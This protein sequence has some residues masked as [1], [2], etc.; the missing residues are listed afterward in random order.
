M[1]QIQ[2]SAKNLNL[3]AQVVKTLLAVQNGQS[4]ASVLNQHIN[5]VSERDRGL[6]HEL[7][8]GCLR[9]WHGLKAITLPLL[10]KPLDNQALESCLYLGLYQILCTRIPAHAAISETVTAAKQ[11]GFE[12]LSGLVN[13]VLRR[14]SRETEEFDLALNQAHGLPSWLFKRLKKD[15]PEQLAELS[16][17][18]KQIAPLTLRVNVNQVS[19]DEYLEI[20]EEEGYEARACTLSEVGIV[21]EQN[22]HIPNLPG[23]EAG[24]FSVQDEHA[25]LCATL[26]P[27]LEGKVVVDACAAPGGKTAHILEK[28]SPKKLYAIDQ[29]AKRLVRVAENLERLLLTEYAEV[30]I[31]AADAINW[32]AP[33]P[34]DCIVLDAPCSAIGV[35]RRHPDIRL[36]RHSTDIPQ[37]V[38][39]QKQILENMWQQLKVGGSLLYITC[40]ILKAENEQQMVEFFA[41]HSDAKEIKIEADWGIEQIH[42]RQL[43]PTA[44]Q[45]DGFFYCHIEKTA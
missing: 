18:L 1:S 43:L 39:L 22:V 35:I 6:Y 37:T 41:Q 13:A 3:R 32:T 9:Q 7:T 4:L 33:E 17:E 36:L 42:G 23:Y 11:L 19:R 26:V 28:Y 45:G 44:D 2:S 30:E 8:L 20:L 16:H 25:Q 29:D 21:L 24:G 15:W 10:T 27:D 14:V 40:S 31:I 5:I 12:P 34:V 38:A